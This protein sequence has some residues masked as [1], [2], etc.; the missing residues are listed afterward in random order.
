MLV[1]RAEFMHELGV[2]SR[3]AHHPNVVTLLGAW[4]YV[5]DVDTV[6]C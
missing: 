1:Q 5:L 2:Q 6:P 3:V 4:H